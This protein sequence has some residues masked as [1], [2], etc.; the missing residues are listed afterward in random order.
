MK[1]SICIGTHNKEDILDEVLYSIFSQNVPFEFE[2]IVADDDSLDNTKDVC[3]HYGVRYCFIEND[4]GKPYRNPAKAR[5]ASYKQAQGD[6]IIC[7]SDDVVHWSDRTIEKLCT[8]LHSGTF[9]IATVH[10]YDPDKKKN[11]EQ[12]TGPNPPFRRPLFFLGSLFKK[13]LY[14][15]G[16]NDE[17]F[18]GPGYEDDW[19]AQCLTQGLD[20]EPVYLKNVAGKH[21]NHSRPPNVPTLYKETEK[22]FKKKKKEA[23]RTGVWKSSGGSW[24]PSN[25]SCGLSILIPTLVSRRSKF[26]KLKAEL[27]KQVRNSFASNVVEI[28]SLEDNKEMIL[29]EKRNKLLEA[30]TK[31]FIVFLDD[32]DWVASNYIQTVLEKINKT[33]EADVIVYPVNLTYKGKEVYCEYS[34]T[35]PDF[36][37]TSDTTWIGKPSHTMPWKRKLAI[38]EKFPVVLFGEDVKWTR[39][40]A[41]KVR[42]EE[43]ID[44]VMYYYRFDPKISETR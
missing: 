30:A 16:G 15:V 34:V 37:Y 3:A 36:K 1:C 8:Q 35:N 31:D 13:D 10:N 6:I 18:I 25:F 42:I 39:K 41:K 21:L 20:L 26:T 40:L 44:Q 27:E 17:D 14:E 29:G 24:T 12:Y 4:S 9:N 2:V 19:F 32:D 7:Q 23:I 28:I 11:L 38:T 22:V 43:K 5:N 33:P